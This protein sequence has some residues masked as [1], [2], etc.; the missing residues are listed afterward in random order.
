MHACLSSATPVPLVLLL[1]PPTH[2]SHV[3]SPR[4]SRLATASPARRAPRHLLLRHRVDAA[5]HASR[6]ST[7]PRA[8]LM[9]ASRPP[10]MPPP[11]H[12][13]P[14]AIKGPLPHLRSSTNLPSPARPLLDH[15]APPPQ[16]PLPIAARRHGPTSTLCPGPNH[17]G[18][19]VPRGLL[20][21]FPLAMAA[22]EPQGRRSGAAGDTPP[23][24]CSMG[25]GRKKT[26]AFAQNPLPFL[27]SVKKPPTS[28]ILLQNKPSPLLYS[29]I[30][31][32]LI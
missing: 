32:S 7:M 14:A 31:H 12:R 9:A 20:S 13:L 21:L 11:L 4:H 25:K 3:R 18:E 15:A 5:I 26:S 1:G 8:P 19:W 6:R 2:C 23:L 28:L 10:P 30:N 29:K 17:G 24:P 16:P 27:Y 22:A